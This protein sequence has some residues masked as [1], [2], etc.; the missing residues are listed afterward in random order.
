MSFDPEKEVTVL[1]R[2]LHGAQDEIG[3]TYYRWR[4]AALELAGPG[5]S[6]LQAGLKAAEVIGEEIGRGLLPRL[7]WLKGEEAWLASLAGAIAANWTN[8][9]ALV[10]VEPGKSGAEAQICWT[11]CPWPTFAKE[12]GAPMEEDVQ[13]CDHI[14]QTLLRDVN[15]FFNVEYRIETQK[16]IPRGQGACV[17]RLYKAEKREA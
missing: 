12:Y 8:Q 15:L 4:K 11:R 17:R 14:L 7:N 16:A 5:V 1:W 13:C 10:K 9:G 3:R 2:S 6:T